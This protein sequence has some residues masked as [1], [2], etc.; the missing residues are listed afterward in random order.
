[1][2]QVQHSTS[3]ATMNRLVFPAGHLVKMFSDESERIASIA[4][5]VA[6]AVADDC[7]CIVITTPERRA[8]CRERLRADGIDADSLAARYQY[9]ELDARMTLSG[10]MKNGECDLPACHQSLDA[11]LRQAAAR[12]R[13][14]QIYG[15][16]SEMLIADGLPEVA[17][18]LEDLCI[19]FCREHRLTTLCGYCGSMLATLPA[20]GRFAERIRLRH[21]HTL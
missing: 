18:E 3:L 1:M 16:L 7:T 9:I 6:D 5:F 14:V 8:A 12:G 21:T 19:D 2:A 20:S 4:A 11:L 17:L 15:E 13:P 10:F